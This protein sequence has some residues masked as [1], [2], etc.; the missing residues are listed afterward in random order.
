MSDVSSAY[1]KIESADSYEKSPEGWA[2]RWSAE[3][4]SAEKRVKKW[5]KQGTRI[6]KRY[7]DKR[8]DQQGERE[9]ANLKAFRVNLFNAN[10]TTQHNMLY[11]NPPKTDVSRRYADADDDHPSAYAEHHGGE[12]RG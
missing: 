11:G 7:Q 9:D 12:Q 4:A 1:E 8:G 2:K 3:M 5:H 6:Q 10:V